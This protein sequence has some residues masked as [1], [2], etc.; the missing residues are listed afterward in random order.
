M[1]PCIC[2]ND[3]NKPQQIPESRWVKE[4]EEYNIIYATYSIPSKTLG[5]YLQELELNESC[6]PYEFYKSNRF[7][8][9][10]E[11]LEK[12]IDFI[13]DCNETAFSVSDLMKEIL[14]ERDVVPG[15]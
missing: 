3:K 12:L 7:A 10:E 11:N 15:K 14:L 2:I 4:G 1:I 5:F 9:S 6:E 8:V 13:R